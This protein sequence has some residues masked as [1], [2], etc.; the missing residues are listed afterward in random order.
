MCISLYVEGM[1][2]MMALDK[3]L[4]M[5]MDLRLNQQ[6][7]QLTQRLKQP[8]QLLEQLELELIALWLDLLHLDHEGFCLANCL[9]FRKGKS[10]GIFCDTWFLR[11]VILRRKKM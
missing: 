7:H 3:L 10:K 9:G 5:G 4:D 2:L 8:D 11:I 6:L 1:L